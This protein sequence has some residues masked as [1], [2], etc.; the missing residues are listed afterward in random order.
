MERK[1]D[2][3]RS[4]ETPDAAGGAPDPG[5]HYDSPEALAADNTLDLAKRAKLLTDWQYGLEEQLD[6]QSEGMGASD[7]IAPAEQ[8]RLTSEL[9]RVARAKAS[10]AD[11][12]ETAG[13]LRPSSGSP[14]RPV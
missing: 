9:E 5:E 7:P 11:E 2:E 10:I 6:A 8:A 12:I 4:T 13:G 1:T 3:P 14:G